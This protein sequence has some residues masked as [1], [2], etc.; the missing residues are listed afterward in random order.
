MLAINFLIN[1]D[2]NINARC[3]LHDY[4]VNATADSRNRQVILILINAEA[5][6]LIDNKA[7]HIPLYLAAMKSYIEAM[8]LLLDKEADIFVA[9]AS[10]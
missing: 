3:D 10:K 1:R 8:K 7:E 2:A 4:V 9:S 6:L 5:S